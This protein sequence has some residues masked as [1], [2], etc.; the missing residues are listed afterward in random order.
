MR[1]DIEDDI[2]FIEDHYPQLTNVYNPTYEAWKRIKAKPADKKCT[3]CGDTVET[4]YHCRRCGDA[5]KVV[6]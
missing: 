6:K 2:K 4:I 3:I 1:S 5:T